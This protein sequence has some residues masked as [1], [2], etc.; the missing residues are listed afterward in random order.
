MDDLGLT[1]LTPSSCFAGFN[2]LKTTWY[3]GLVGCYLPQLSL[4]HSVLQRYMFSDELLYTIHGENHSLNVAF[5]PI[6]TMLASSDAA[7]MPTPMV[8]QTSVAA[9][10]L[11]INLSYLQEERDVVGKS[12]GMQ[13]HVWVC[14]GTWGGKAWRN[15]DQYPYAYGRGIEHW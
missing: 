8:N 1:S 13:S 10:A 14:Q 3:V 12:R 2:K 7:L 15:I 5:L 6:S 11:P 9:N 4:C